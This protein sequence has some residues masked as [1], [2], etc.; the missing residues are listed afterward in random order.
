M[1]GIVEL[2]GHYLNIYLVSAMVSRRAIKYYVDCTVGL[3]RLSEYLFSVSNGQPEGHQILCGWYHWIRRILFKYLFGVGNGQ[4][5]GP[6]NI[7]WM[8]PSD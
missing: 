7:M 1:D 5:E 3:G 6:S 2:G 8:V 4:P